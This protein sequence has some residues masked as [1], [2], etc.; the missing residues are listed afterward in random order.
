MLR[1]RGIESRT[2]T[3]F[4]QEPH[5]AQVLINELIR[6]YLE[7]NGRPCHRPWDFDVWSTLFDMMLRQCLR[8]WG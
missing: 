6:E 8:L 1:S 7:Y 2:L 3:L 5:A 4:A